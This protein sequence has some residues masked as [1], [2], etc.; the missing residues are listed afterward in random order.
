MATAIVRRP[1]ALIVYCFSI[2]EAGQWLRTPCSDAAY[3]HAMSIGQLSLAKLQ[4]N[5]KNTS[6]QRNCKHRVDV[7]EFVKML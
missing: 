2:V 6:E 1:P 7:H 5:K 4:G 3:T